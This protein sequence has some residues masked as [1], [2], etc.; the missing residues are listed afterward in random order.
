MSTATDPN[1]A[2]SSGA[3]AIRPP[4]IELRGVWR[5]FPRGGVRA[6][7]DVSL[8]IH[9]GEFV[10]VTGPSGSGKST[11]MN[12]LGC[13]D[14]PS[15]GEY[16][17]A[18]RDVGELGPDQLA[19]LRRAAFGFVFQ[20]YN[21]IASAT[22]RENVELP[23]VYA[24]LARVRR[25]ARAQAL[26][27][28][29]GLGAR[30]RHRPTALSGGEQQR[31]AVARALMN[32]GQVILADEPTGALDATNGIE[33]MRVLRDLAERGHAVVVISHDPE[34]AAWAERRIEL[35]DGRI[36][37]DARQS[38][39]APADADVGAL[40]QTS[41]PGFA[42]AT[43]GERRGAAR[44]PPW[45]A[46]RESVRAGFES[47][48]ANLLRTSR[49]RTA[50]TVLGVALGV[51]S[52]VSMLGVVQGGYQ[53]GVRSAARAGAD[54]IRIYPSPPL[55]DQDV[56][57]VRLGVA[58][59][60]AIRERIPNVRTVLPSLS[61]RRTMRRG[62][63]HLEA[64]VYAA[65]A[66]SMAVEKRRL[67]AGVFLDGHDGET[68]QPVAVIGA[69]LRDALFTPAAEPLGDYVLIDGIPFLV[70]GVL[71]WSGAA[72]M[73]D[74]S[75]Y[76]PLE[77]AQA[78]LF[79]SERLDAID[80]LVQDAR[81]AGQVAGA[82]RDLLMRRHGREGFDVGGNLELQLGLSVIE[83][84]LATLLAAVGAISL[85]VG[86]M[87]VLSVMLV[88][89]SDRTREIG[90]RMAAGA[91]R[92][93]ILRQF[94]LEALAVTG[95]GGALGTVL[96][97]ASIPVLTAAGLPASLSAWFVFAALGCA[98]AT[99]LVAGIVPAHRAAGLDPVRALAR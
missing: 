55:F 41:M 94:L 49:L 73:L 77:T 43:A 16:R 85:F 5:I 53:E 93:D 46:V 44:W 22:A 51:W 97:F 39:R 27:R 14:R 65:T 17:F 91:R 66:E 78:L 75:V 28:G 59:A 19:G 90:I 32:G 87:G 92:R 98:T 67:T 13:L 81:R 62:E 76:V 30:L 36:V 20:S 69:G 11:L 89:V 54:T 64:R 57:P 2:V 47:L 88:S 18:G 99:G 7:V 48:R 83:K 10:C 21:L 1:R 79:G 12:I 52:V 72:D 95:A 3:A 60:R 56:E 9:P 70:K 38:P 37:A 24:R 29:L 15:R 82:V 40:A 71:S 31:V 50:L 4:L 33:V 8:R 23:A 84:L 63:R 74:T 6:L 68:F 42:P 61:G 25:A 26:L 35:L 34:V 58:D 45:A 86:G 96:G 80:V